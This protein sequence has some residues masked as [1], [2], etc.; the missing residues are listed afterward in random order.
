MSYFLI[1]TGS[2]PLIDD[3]PGL[4]FVPVKEAQTY[5]A[6]IVSDA[7]N[8]RDHDVTYLLDDG[9]MTTDTVITEAS[10]QMAEGLTFEATR[11]GQVLLR[12]LDA[13]CTVR[14][15]WPS[16]AGG[17]PDLDGFDHPVRFIEQLTERLRSGVDLNSA[18]E[19]KA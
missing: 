12:L 17:L 16:Q 7:V 5:V 15:W 8:A 19:P 1:A 11:L 3:V 4:R 10:D 13:G 2:V 14:V 6:D 18:Y 9:T